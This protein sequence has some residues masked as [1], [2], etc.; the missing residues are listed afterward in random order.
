M[1]IFLYSELH[2]ANCTLLH[3]FFSFQT[4]DGGLERFKT[5]FKRLHNS[6]VAQFCPINYLLPK[7]L[8]Y[9]KWVFFLYLTMRLLVSLPGLVVLLFAASKILDPQLNL[10]FLSTSFCALAQNTDLDTGLSGR[11]QE[12]AALVEM[13]ENYNNQKTRPGAQ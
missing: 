5:V 9:S 1:S 13:F 11:Q 3:N 4:Y 2:I 7:N 12:A 10:C 8:L 6:S